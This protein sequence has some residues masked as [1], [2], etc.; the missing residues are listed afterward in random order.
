MSWR[1]G[2][3]PS[4]RQWGKVRLQVLDRDSWRCQ[5]CGKAALLEIDHV[6]PLEDGGALYDLANLQTLCVGCHQAKSRVERGGRAPDPEGAKWRVYLTKLHYVVN[7]VGFTQ[8]S[9]YD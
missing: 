9:V 3:R 7:T 4:R 1:K 6:K 2:E 5:K 8:Y